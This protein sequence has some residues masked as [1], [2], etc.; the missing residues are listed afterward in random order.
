MELMV[1]RAE[2]EGTRVPRPVF[3]RPSRVGLLHTCESVRS[4]HAGMTWDIEERSCAP[5]APPNDVLSRFGYVSHERV[6]PKGCNVVELAQKK[7][8]RNVVR[9]W[10]ALGG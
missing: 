9:M 1:E 2:A 6:A 7:A 8:I 4:D 10:R 3:W 5:A